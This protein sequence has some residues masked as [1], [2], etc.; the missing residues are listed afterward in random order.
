VVAE[1]LCLYRQS[2]MTFPHPF[3][4]GREIHRAALHHFLHRL[5]NL[6]GR[7]WRQ[8]EFKANNFEGTGQYR[9][10]D[11][12]TYTGGWRHNK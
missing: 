12:A 7:L 10:P 9:W 5:C 2:H 3:Y 11:G 6:D 8:G 4:E 1:I